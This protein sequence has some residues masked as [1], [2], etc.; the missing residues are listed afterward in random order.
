MTGVAGTPT[1]EE[2]LVEEL[3]S[4]NVVAADPT[5]LSYGKVVMAT[6]SLHT[7]W[8]SPCIWLQCGL[9]DSVAE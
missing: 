1:I 3:D 2:W 9:L 8:M 4:G 7:S 6:C 5:V